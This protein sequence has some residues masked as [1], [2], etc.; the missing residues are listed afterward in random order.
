MR[1]KEMT[2]FQATEEVLTTYKNRLVNLSSKNRSLRLGKLAKLRSFD[3]QQLEFYEQFAIPTMMKKI[4]QAKKSE[5]EF[6]I[7]PQM[8]K[9]QVVLEKKVAQVMFD[10]EQSQEE[11]EVLEQE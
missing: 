2:N 9:T 1:K 5:L 10:W 8:N 7:V 3:L 6:E 11:I 4:N